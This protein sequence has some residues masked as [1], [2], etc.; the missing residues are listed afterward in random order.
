[1]DEL[2]QCNPLV[3]KDDNR[4]KNIRTHSNS[5]K[6]TSTGQDGS[7]TRKYFP[8]KQGYP[9]VST[10]RVGSEGIQMTVD[11]KHITSFAFREVIPS[12]SLIF[13]H[14]IISLW[15]LGKVFCSLVTLLYLCLDFGAMARK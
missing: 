3:G 15:L 10:L 8:F 4:S 14:I 7:V 2:D 6:L 9:S 11:G 1:M 12:C 5:S 13:P